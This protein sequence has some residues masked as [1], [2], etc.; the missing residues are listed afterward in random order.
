[1][2]CEKNTTPQK[3]LTETTQ[4]V[5]TISKFRLCDHLRG[6]DLTVSDDEDQFTALV[7]NFLQN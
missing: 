7:A 5:T 2:L 1:M 6:V 4:T 3:P